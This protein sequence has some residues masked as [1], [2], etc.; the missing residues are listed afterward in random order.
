MTMIYAKNL[1]LYI[2]FA[3]LISI[4]QLI[5]SIHCYAESFDE[6]EAFSSILALNYCH[7]SLAKIISYNDRIVLDEEYNNIIN[8]INLSKIHDEEILSIIKS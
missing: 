7:F 8:N 5:A 2:L 4:T 6:S 1:F 3:I